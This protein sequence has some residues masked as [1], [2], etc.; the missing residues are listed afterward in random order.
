M[1]PPE[2]RL[3]IARPRKIAGPDLLPAQPGREWTPTRTCAQEIF[4]PTMRNDTGQYRLSRQQRS[5]FE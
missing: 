3:S 5:V 1:K 2:E 4:H